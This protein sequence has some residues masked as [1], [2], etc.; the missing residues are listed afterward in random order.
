MRF[1]AISLM[2]LALAAGCAGGGQTEMK[3]Y[4]VKKEIAATPGSASFLA[5]Q[6]D[7]PRHHH[8]YGNPK[9][10][11]TG[12]PTSV[13][14]K[15][16]KDIV[17]QQAR[18]LKPKKFYFPGEREFTWGYDNTTR[19]FLPFMVSEKAVVGEKKIAVFFDSLLC[20]DSAS[21]EPASCIR[22]QY[23]LDA[24]VT[25][26]SD[27]TRITP[28]D[29]GILKEFRSS[30]EGHDEAEATG[31]ESGDAPSVQSPIPDDLAF[32]PRYMDR[33]V[34]GILQAILFGILAGIIL[35]VMPCVLPVVSL[36]VMHF[37]QIAGSSRRRAFSLG[38]MFSLGILTVFAI[39]AALAAFFGYRWGGL[40]QH[41]EFLIAMTAV[42]F[43]L[44]LSLAGLYTLPV[45]GFA[46]GL[47]G[48][49]TG[50]YADAFVKGMVATLLAT[51]CSGPLLGGTLAWAMT[52]TPLV[53][54]V[55][56]MSVGVGMA[57]PYLILTAWPRMLRILPKPGEWV[58][59]FEGIMF[60]LLMFTVV[61]LL[62]VFD[63]ETVVPMV[64][65]LSIVAL[66]LWQYGIFANP[67]KSRVS[68]VLS[69]VALAGIIA[70]GYLVSFH[71]FSNQEEISPEETKPF[72]VQ[73]VLANRQEGRV[74][75]VNFT[76]AWCPNCKL[77]EHTALRAG[78]VAEAFSGAGVDYMVADITKANPDAEWLMKKLGS[79]SIPLLAVMPAG[80]G[81]TS[82]I[83]LRDIYSAGDVLKAL[84]MARSRAPS[85]EKVHFELNVPKDERKGDITPEE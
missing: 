47:S 40:F 2:V 56:F 24:V 63:R 27:V 34:A 38:A 26:V 16:P 48:P 71:V 64:L 78:K 5:V 32:S 73:R 10:P 81:F 11:G 58:K 28:W 1:I 85:V 6:V 4:L 76:A 3:V 62:S 72:S 74:S 80:D 50:G 14:A 45:P 36:K 15:G 39:L 44:G 19:I 22:K 7:L 12:L 53:I 68:R 20:N 13:T 57:L 43:A 82:P 60:F 17:F 54:A 9:G 65:F 84:D 67:A 66:G 37:I 77:V 23:N 8:I 79:H 18:F 61:Y 59:V 83:L 75:V 30:F 51:P 46:G 41:R 35:N 70:G 42:V 33:A 25:V 29:E 69:T 31:Y 49:S 55:I 21:S 52:Q